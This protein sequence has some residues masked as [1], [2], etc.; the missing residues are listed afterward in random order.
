MDWFEGHYAADRQ[1]WRAS[2]PLADDLAGVAPALVCTCEYDPLRPEGDE[3][4]ARL[5]ASGVPVT[6]RVFEGL[7]H[8]VLG[9]GALVPAAQALMDE[10]CSALSKELA[11]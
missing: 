2:P 8:G 9:M 6:H 7:C 4:A 5:E 10:C 1:D 11:P 3:Y